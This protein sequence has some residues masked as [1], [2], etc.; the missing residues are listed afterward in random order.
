MNVAYRSRLAVKLMFYIYIT[1]VKLG[2]AM[3]G[4]SGFRLS[5]SAHVYAKPTKS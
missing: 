1:G 3:W 5:R 2:F 4:L